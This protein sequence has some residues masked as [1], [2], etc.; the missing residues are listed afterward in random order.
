[1]DTLYASPFSY[2]GVRYE[3][4]SPD[5]QDNRRCARQV[6]IFFSSLNKKSYMCRN[7]TLA[8][9]QYFAKLDI[10]AYYEQGDKL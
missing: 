10:D 2:R 3:I 1:M 8:R 5:K 9:A 7:C 6:T 4:A